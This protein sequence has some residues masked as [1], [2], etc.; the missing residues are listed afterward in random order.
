MAVRCRILLSPCRTAEA[1]GWSFRFTTRRLTSVTHREQPDPIA[2]AKEFETAGD[3]CVY[4]N[5]I[6]EAKV[7]YGGAIDALL[8][9]RAF[10]DAIRICL[11]LIRLSP[12]VVR[13]RYTLLFLL[14]GL[15]RYAEARAQLE[16]YVRVVIRSG[17]KSFAIPRLQLLAHVTEDAETTAFIEDILGDLG[18]ER[19]GFGV[20]LA[21]EHLATDPP[22]AADRVDRWERLLPI[23]LRDD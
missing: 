20:H 22:G 15:G 1:G 19:L 17:T 13:T 4:R 23:A 5:S 7:N 3:E 21:S 6:E 16:A 18:A 14:I 10:H 12:E 8:E 9:A 11:R 2:R